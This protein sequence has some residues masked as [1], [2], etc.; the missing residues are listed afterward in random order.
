MLLDRFE[1]GRVTN[2]YYP[3]LGNVRPDET[4]V[5]LRPFVPGVLGA[6]RADKSGSR[7]HS[8]GPFGCS[9]P[10]RRSPA[11]LFECFG[12]ACY[13]CRSH[14]REGYLIL[15]SEAEVIGARVPVGMEGIYSPRWR[16]TF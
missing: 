1:E 10:R 12:Y 14:L 4:T 5:D 3:E 6:W 13:G 15:R 11:R 7:G 9:S 8:P 2:T 16:A